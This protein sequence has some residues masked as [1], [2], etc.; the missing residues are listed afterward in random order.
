MKQGLANQAREKNKNA[1]AR[2]GFIS[3]LQGKG[4][5]VAGDEPMDDPVGRTSYRH[6][7]GRRQRRNVKMTKDVER[8]DLWRFIMNNDLISFLLRRQSTI[9]RA[10]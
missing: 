1:L 4:E 5:S 10:T 9:L 2:Y 6:A 3:Q 7:E 8:E